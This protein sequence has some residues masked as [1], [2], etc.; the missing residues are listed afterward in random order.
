V[1][2]EP[3]FLEHFQ[4]A[5]GN[6]CTRLEFAA[7]PTQE[8]RIQSRLI[9][10]SLPRPEPPPMLRGLPWLADASIGSDYFGGSGSP[11]VAA[12][13]RQLFAETAGAPLE[14]LGRLCQWLYTRMDR[15]IRVEGAAQSPDET[16]ATRRG[17]CRDLTLLFAAVCRS[18]GMASRFVSG[19]QGQEDTPDGKRHLHAWPEV[20]IPGAG[21]LGWDPTHGVATGPAHVALCAAPDQEPTMPVQGG[22]YFTGPSITSTL[23]YAITFD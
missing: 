19:Y 22:F 13:A 21:W 18:Q 15:Q 11:A 4:D 1:T 2:P 3:Q 12:L 8:L 5:F 10:E 20:W 7:E 9:V 14:F 6:R 17:A 16:L 23:E